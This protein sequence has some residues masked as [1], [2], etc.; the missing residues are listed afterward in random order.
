MTPL[1]LALAAV[2]YFFRLLCPSSSRTEADTYGQETRTSDS[3]SL[4]A[5]ALAKRAQPRS[6]TTAMALTRAYNDMPILSVFTSVP[7]CSAVL[8]NVH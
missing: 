6:A 1:R 3:R 2:P 8:A 5:T 7:L 4:S